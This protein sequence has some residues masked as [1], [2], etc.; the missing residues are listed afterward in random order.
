L[1]E[2]AA[3]FDPAFLDPRCT[4]D[5]VDRFTQRSAILRAIRSVGP[6]LHGTLLD[7]GCGT[8]PYRPLITAAP[9]R[10]TKYVGVDL[11]RPE[12]AKPDVVWDGVTI[13]LG[14][15]TVDCAIATEVFEHCPDPERVMGE[16]WRVIKPGGFLFFTVPFLWPLH[17]VP[18]DEYRYTPFA[19][20]RHLRRGG[21][22]TVEIAALGG[23]DASLA[24]MLGLWV[25]RRWMQPWQ[26]ATLGR[27]I[28][29]LV[30][31]LTRGDQPPATFQ[32]DGMITGLAGRAFKAE[33]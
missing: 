16:A 7:I 13:P 27:V 12:Y 14:D 23:W 8:M 33:S 32:H 6:S 1:R 28:T 3:P 11:G 24:Q 5:A 25:Q 22:A 10:V 17:C 9:S 31:W 20:E 30:G 18:Y 21:F 19:L 2:T 4:F 26:R 29:P 15:E